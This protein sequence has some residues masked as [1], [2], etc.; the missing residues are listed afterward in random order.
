[1]KN[2][3]FQSIDKTILKTILQKDTSRQIWESMK[4]K[5]QRNAR[6]Q[7]AQLQALLRDIE[8]LEMKVGESVTDYFSRVMLVANNMRNFGEKMPYVKVVEKILCSLTEQFNYLVCSIEESKDIDFHSIDELQ[9]SLTIH[10]QKFQKRDGEEHV[11]RVSTEAKQTTRERGKNAHQGRGRGRGRK[12]FNRNTFECYKCHKLGHFQYECPSWDKEA[13]YA[14]FV[15]IEEILLMSYVEINNTRKE[16]VWFLDSG[17]SNHMCGIRSIFSEFDDSFRHVI[18]LGNN[19]KMNV[20]G[21]GSVKLKINGITHKV[22]EVYYI[23]ELKNNLL[24]IGKLQVKRLGI[25]IQSGTCRIYL[26]NRGL[27]I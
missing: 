15:E 25:L 5:Y 23:P 3:L 17:C 13:N 6:V 8:I 12:S 1:M 16:E 18:K 14:E 9:S 20:L 22:T 2:F 10:E 24:S 26:P 11:L 4:R 7:C 19:T 21:R 27:I